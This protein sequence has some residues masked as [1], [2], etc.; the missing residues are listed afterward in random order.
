MGR[1]LRL[2]TDIIWAVP[3]SYEMHS[4]VFH[5]HVVLSVLVVVKIMQLAYS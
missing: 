3:S 2:A 4:T 1:C 5:V